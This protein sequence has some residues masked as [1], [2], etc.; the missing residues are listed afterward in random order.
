MSHHGIFRNL[1][2]VEQARYQFSNVKGLF[3]ETTSIHQTFVQSGS[4]VCF[5]DVWWR[6]MTWNQRFP[7]KWFGIAHVILVIFGFTPL[8]VTICVGP[9]WTGSWNYFKSYKLPPSPTYELVY[10]PLQLRRLLWGISEPERILDGIRAHKVGPIH[11]SS[12]RVKLADGEDHKVFLLVNG[13]YQCSYI[14]ADGEKAWQ[15]N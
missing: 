8:I 6:L 11:D 5:V 15:C 10:K 1:W 7:P 14:I 3:R 9:F 13:I 2:S 4:M 12:Y